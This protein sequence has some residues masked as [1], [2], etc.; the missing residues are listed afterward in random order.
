MIMNTDRILDKLHK[1]EKV[2][3]WSHQWAKLEKDGHVIRHNSGAGFKFVPVKKNK[4][5]L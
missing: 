2:F 5:P 3:L 4:K 1:N